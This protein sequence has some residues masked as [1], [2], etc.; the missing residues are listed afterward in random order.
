MIGLTILFFVIDLVS[1]LVVS[2]YLILYKNYVLIGGFFNLTYVK[3]TGAAWSILS[4]RINL[5]IIISLIVIILG[6]VY[7]Y[8]NKPKNKYVK[9]AYAMILGGSIGNL[10]DR[11]V[12]GYVIDF[13]DLN[14]FGYN[15]PIF[16][17]ADS[18]IVIGV[19]I[20]VISTWRD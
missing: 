20:Y 8:K 12:Y 4:G 13:L 11:I 19:I 15:Y 6:F 16:N 1:K 14:L 10:F 17:L 3:N 18:F 9:I 5:L 2:N 7:A